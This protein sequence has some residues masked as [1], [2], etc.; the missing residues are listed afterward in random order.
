[1]WSP[2]AVGL[3]DAPDVQ[4]LGQLEELLVL[5]GGVEQDGVA[6]GLVAQHEDVVVVRAHDELVD[7]DLG[8]VVVERHA[9]SLPRR[10][11]ARRA[12]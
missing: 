12:A 10:R 4:A 1:M 2:V 7:L 9:P 6:G 11:P 3:E 8:V 5:V